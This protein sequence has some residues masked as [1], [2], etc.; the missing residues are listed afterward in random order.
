MADQQNVLG[1]SKTDYMT[2]EQ[3]F[4]A[5]MEQN[6]KR[7]YRLA[8]HL[9]GD[10]EEARDATQETFVRAWKKIDKL[11]WETSR[12][13]LMKIAVN[14]CLD[15]LRRRKFRENSLREGDGSHDSLEHELRDPMPNPLDNCQSKEVQDKVREAISKLP[16]AYRSVLILRDLEGLSYQEIADVL[17]TR[18]SKVKSDLFR[19]RQQLKEILR[20]I[21]G[22]GR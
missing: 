2:D 17:K 5:L 13:W 14:L 9:L 6:Q 7:V 19:G 1:I 22:V 12:A 15:C 20:P 11:K 18:M 8:Y 4:V 21:F 3:N 16:P 10:A